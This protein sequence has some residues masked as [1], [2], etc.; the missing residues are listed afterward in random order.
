[1][2]KIETQFKKAHV[3]VVD[4]FTFP[5]H[6]DR[7]FCGV[8]NPINI[9]TR[10]GV[11]ADLKALRVGDIVFFYQRRVDESP[12]ERGFRGVYEI[13]SEPFFDTREIKGCEFPN[14]SVRGECPFCGKPFSTKDIEG[15]K[16]RKCPSCK[17]THSYHILPNRV[18]ITLKEYYE[19]P[20]DDNTAYI[21]HTN[22]GM[23]WTMLFRKIF[24]PG[25]ERSIN[26]ILP[27]EGEK[28]IRLLK[29]I[30]GKPTEFLYHQPY[31]VDEKILSQKLY[32]ELGEGPTVAYESILEAWLM[33]NIDKDIPVLKEIIGPPE[34]LE[35]FGNNI[36]Y[37]I[38][39]EKVDILCL[40]NKE[41]KRYKATV[42]E[43]KRKGID[44]RGVEQ[45]EEYPYWIAQ[46][47]TVNLPYRDKLK[48]FEVQPVFI[49]HTISSN[50]KK[51][52]KGIGEKKFELP[53][54]NPCKIIVKKTIVL[55][56]EV[57]EENII[58]ELVSFHSI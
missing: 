21:N 52:I 34:E 40:H 44:K 47:V 32:I 42:I 46:L 50:I 12:R 31:P 3:F 29:R 39:G 17:R 11:Y 57:K 54:Q 8:K 30:N 13:S 49:A 56:Y 55:K 4:K 48:L 22:H 27:E 23:L 19:K 36:L 7:L 53:Y 18:L 41:G 33:E 37:G 2:R 26:P 25:R 45:I 5:V 15:N 58:F 20:V 28:L 35:Y 43:L 14:L 38:G 1:M 51:S 16:K 9:N 6:R 24:G 10:Y